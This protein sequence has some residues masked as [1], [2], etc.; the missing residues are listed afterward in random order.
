MDFPKFNGED[1][2]NWLD[3]AE[4]YFEIKEI[5]RRDCV[6]I[7]SYYL[8]GDARQWWRWFEQTNDGRSI[9]WERFRRGL[10]LRF[11]TSQIEDAN[12]SMSKLRQTGNFRDYLK[13]FEK[14]VNRVPH[15]PPSAVLGAFMAGLKPEFAAE[16]K[17]WR[18]RDLQEAIELATR[19]D[20]QLKLARPSTSTYKEGFINFQ[21][22]SAPKAWGAS[23]PNTISG[24]TTI[25]KSVP[26][27]I[28]VVKGRIQLS[29]DE[30]NRRRQA[31]LCF[32]CNEKYSWN[33]VC[34]NAKIMSLIVEE[35]EP[36]GEEDKP[37]YDEAIGEPSADEAIIEFNQMINEDNRSTGT[38]LETLDIGEGGRSLRFHGKIGHLRIVLTILEDNQFVIKPSK[39]FFGVKEVEYLGHFISHKG[40]RVDPKKIAA[41]QKWPIPSN[42][43][44]LRGFLGL[45]GYYRKFCPKFGEIARALHNLTKRNKFKWSEDAQ[46]AFQNLKTAM[47]S[48]PVLALPDF[49]DDFVIETDA[50]G[51]GIGAVLS[52]KG[53]PIA[54]MSKGIAAT[55]QTWSIY[56]KEMLAIL[57]AIR[58]WRPYL[59]GRRFKLSPTNGVL[60]SCWSSASQRPNSRNRLPN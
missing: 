6:K 21:R 9:T 13:D 5:R 38:S 1:P 48:T 31:G 56:E 39:C 15:W 60:D 3:K 24:E 57:E 11:G 26:A 35:V 14:L 53:R 33:H 51:L 7:A 17:M 40:V 32:T 18:P 47:S 50:S 52:Q 43:S 22:N 29:N 30:I 27:S 37:R 36:E 4:Q 41:V 54:F 8:D 42:V 34:A 23:T 2:I 25:P 55:K 12:E 19:K 44:E 28:S 46:T 49:D 58:C 59:I 16:L 10:L 45:A 20:E